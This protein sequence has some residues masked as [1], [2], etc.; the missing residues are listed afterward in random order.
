[1]IAG[2]ACEACQILIGR[3]LLADQSTI[4]YLLQLPYSETRVA[5]KYAVLCLLLLVTEPTHCPLRQCYDLNNAFWN[6]L[7]SMR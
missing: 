2:A 3:T 4:V 7:I 1:M 6:P 5:S